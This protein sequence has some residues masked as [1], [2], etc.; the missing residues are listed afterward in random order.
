MSTNHTWRFFRAGG[1][2][3]VKLDTGADLLAIDQLD[4]KLWVALAC[5]TS[6]LEFDKETLALIDTDK[7]GRV[8][9][10]ELIAAV[11]WAGN[12]LR[13]PDDLLRSSPTLRPAAIN[14]T[15]AE[16]TLIANFARKVLGKAESAE[17]TVEE[18]A[19]AAQVFAAKPFNGDGIVPAD[20]AGDDATKAVIN[21]II[22]CLGS[23]L[24]ASG[25]PGINQAKVDQF[26]TDAAAYSD[27]WKKAEGNAAL[28]PLGPGT[29]AAA[30][31]VK[32]VKAK[33][34]D[35]FARCRLAAF[36]PRSV[37]A[38]NRDEK[39]FLALGAKDLTA[40]NADIAGFPLAQ[41]SANKPLPLTQGINPAWAGAMA[42]FQ[43]AAVKPI[44][45]ERAS[46][47]EADWAALLAK[48][49]AFEAWTGSKAG[50]SVEKIGVKRVREILAGKAK[51]TLTAL[52]AKD[53]A[54][55][56]NA[57]AVVGLNRLA[58]YHRDLNQLCHNFVS[59][60][61]FYGRKN[62][63]IFQAGTLY[64]D[65][66]SCDLCLTVEDAGKHAAM[67]ALAGTYLAYCDCYRKGTGEKMQI[68][69]AFTGG[70]SDN[71]MVGRNGIFFDRKGRDWDA[72]ITKIIDNPISIRQAFFAPYKKLVRMIE[73]QVAKRAAAADAASDA[74]LA[75]AAK[76]TAGGELP[77]PAEPPKT[78]FDTGTLA[79]IGLVLTT[80]LAALGGIFGKIVGL[81]WWQI[82]LV[83]I[84]ILLAISAPSMIMAWLKLRRRNL[85][86]ILDAN[87]WAVNAKAK[88]NV[89]FGGALTG[90]A[91]LPPGSQRD[92]VDPFAE[93]K[94][95]WPKI[96][97]VLILL[98][99]AAFFL[100]KQGC[101]PTPRW[102]CTKEPA[103]VETA[104]PAPAAPADA[105][106]KPAD[107]PQ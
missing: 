48:L 74:K 95:P 1:F 86:P 68:V 71:L 88:M 70:D 55:E 34:D 89:P 31:A 19:A 77:K 79:A 62:K 85:G 36:D 23:V 13:N 17:I 32:A 26:F 20:S 38:L 12:L 107:T 51:E 101:I 45:G 56:G 14:D 24:D 66:R 15:T 8:R 52:I 9:A 76:A 25:K 105:A 50:G 33:V 102:C 3:Q 22:E 57:Q 84:I 92:L 63:A 99:V 35:Y 59:F 2:D 64:L 97:V 91:A 44:L 4:L 46:L 58:H 61:D 81:P 53:K 18:A 37:N 104:V 49:G 65:Q 42:T 11:K 41:I 80:L 100:L 90:V 75:A 103:K 98:A 29:E 43:A 27:W 7:D 6:G 83:I 67:A 106:A 93:K 87:G 78:K 96:I 16:G 39:E 82:P 94:S 54:E 5:P 21:D 73:E 40:A 10:P 69:A 28:L 60:S 30:T 72:T 47:T